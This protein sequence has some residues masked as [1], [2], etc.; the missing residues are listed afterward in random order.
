MPESSAQKRERPLCSITK[1]ATAFRFEKDDPEAG[2]WDILEATVKR[3]VEKRSS[4]S[5]CEAS[6]VVRD[7]QTA[8][9]FV[10]TASDA[11]FRAFSNRG[12]L[13]FCL[14]IRDAKEGPLDPIAPDERIANEKEVPAFVIGNNLMPANP[15]K[16][17]RAEVAANGQ[18]VIRIVL[19][20]DATNSFTNI[21]KENVGKRLAIVLVNDGPSGGREVL[22]A[23]MLTGPIENGEVQL[24]GNFSA[25]EAKSLAAELPL[26]PFPYSTSRIAPVA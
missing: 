14:V 4:P 3:V 23:A 7:E 9:V 20:S 10:D 26:G 2:T 8:D 24:T 11:D 6:V 1:G 22:T 19:S 12:G 13:E 18:W 21:T 5:T 25:K 15:V 17:A 16:S